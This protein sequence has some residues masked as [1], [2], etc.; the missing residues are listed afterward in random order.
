[1]FEVEDFC[2]II[3]EETG[4]VRKGQKEDGTIIFEGDT[5]WIYVVTN[6]K[7]FLAESFPKSEIPWAFYAKK[8]K[9]TPIAKMLNSNT[10]EEEWWEPQNVN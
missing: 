7:S 8:W 10:A 3:A 5:F 4:A 2:R 6:P 9:A 1:M